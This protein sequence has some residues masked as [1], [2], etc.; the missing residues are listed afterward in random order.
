MQSLPSSGAPLY[1]GSHRYQRQS[2][3]YVKARSLKQSSFSFISLRHIYLVLLTQLHSL[4]SFLT[5]RTVGSPQIK[6]IKNRREWQAFEGKQAGAPNDGFLLNTLKALVGYP[7]K[8]MH[9]KWHYKICTC[10]VIL[11]EFESFRNYNYFTQYFLAE[12]FRCCL[13]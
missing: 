1:F 5:R 9:S 11:G 4:G 2:R 6:N 13:T 10:S 8:I 12:N 3:H 7:A